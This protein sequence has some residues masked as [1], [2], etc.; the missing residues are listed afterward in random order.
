MD[1]VDTM[2]SWWARWWKESLVGLVGLVMKD[3]STLVTFN[4]SPASNAFE[5]GCRILFRIVRCGFSM[6]SSL[7]LLLILSSGRWMRSRLF[8]LVASSDSGVNGHSSQDLEGSARSPRSSSSTSCSNCRSFSQ[9]QAQ[10]EAQVQS[11]Y[12]HEHLSK[13]PT[14]NSNW[15]NGGKIRNSSSAIWSASSQAQVPQVPFSSSSSLLARGMVFRGS[16]SRFS[17]VPDRLCG[18][19]YS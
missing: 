2:E 9:A 19:V 3:P 16:S 4:Q 13:P 10:T 15:S 7:F 14:S 17:R 8:L 5:I 6:L 11:S 12:A 1:M 18:G